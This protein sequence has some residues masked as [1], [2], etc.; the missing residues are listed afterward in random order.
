MVWNIECS[1][2]A[3]SNRMTV[4]LARSGC[5]SERPAFFIVYILASSYPYQPPKDYDVEGH[6]ILGCLTED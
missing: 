6:K 1:G 5:R 2:R 3:L 4:S